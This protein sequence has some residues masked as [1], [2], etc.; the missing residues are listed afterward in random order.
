MHPRER[1]REEHRIDVIAAVTRFVELVGG[2]NLLQLEG[3]TID[4]E[5]A[6]AI[7]VRIATREQADVNLAAFIG[8]T[9]HAVIELAEYG[10]ARNCGRKRSARL[11]GR[12]K[13]TRVGVRVKR[14]RLEEIGGGGT[15]VPWLVERRPQ[16]LQRPTR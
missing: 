2:D 14:R 8:D 15:G 3:L 12:N 9:R 11:G 13:L 5:L 4:V 7:A 1:H 10:H 6:Q 16:K